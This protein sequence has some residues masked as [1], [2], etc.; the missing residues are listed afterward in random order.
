MG[1]FK[2]KKEIIFSIL[3]II[4][5]IILTNVILFKDFSLFQIKF[6][7]NM[8]DPRSNFIPF[9]EM[10]L[11]FKDPTPFTVINFVGNILLL[12]PCGILLP[13]IIGKKFI[14]L[15]W[16]IIFTMIL[17]LFFEVL[18]ILFII[19]SFD[20]DDLILNTFGAC[21]GFWI[22][23]Y[24]IKRGKVKSEKL[25]HLLNKKDGQAQI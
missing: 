16:V 14:S 13:L 10:Y 1:K 2:L 20:V 22:L 21:I 7:S 18:Q 8:Q 19:G 3:F 4:Y 25:N 23:A 17:C 15:K 9:Y 5:S 24:L 11:N 6:Q 12:V